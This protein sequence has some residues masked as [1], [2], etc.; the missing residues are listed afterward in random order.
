VP[1]ASRCRCFSNAG[2]PYLLGEPV[3]KDGLLRWVDAFAAEAMSGEARGNPADP[4]DDRLGH[5]GLL[6]I[7]EDGA[8]QV[9][10]VT[11][12]RYG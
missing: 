12:C 5:D 7:W 3:L 1:R 4:I 9:A 11:T 6:W 10:D 2:G 8:Q